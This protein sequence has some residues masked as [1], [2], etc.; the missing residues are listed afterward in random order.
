MLKRKFRGGMRHVKGL[1]ESS[2]ISALVLGAGLLVSSCAVTPLLPDTE[3]VRII[4]HNELPGLSKT[5]LSDC[6]YLGTV[7]SSEGHWYD[8]IYISNADLSRGSLND[9]HNQASQMGANIVY[10]DNNID[11]KTSVTFLGQAYRCDVTANQ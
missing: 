6:D 8:F 1:V 4:F 5:S 11:F 9:M 10:I 3:P 7:I 2:L